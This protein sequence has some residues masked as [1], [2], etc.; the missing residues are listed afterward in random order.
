MFV[1]GRTM[2]SVARLTLRMIDFVRAAWIW[3]ITPC[4]AALDP[5]VP[6]VLLIAGKDMAARI[7]MIATT[8]S[9]S[10][11]VKPA[12]R[13]F[14]APSFEQEP[15]LERIAPASILLYFSSFEAMISSPRLTAL[16]P[17]DPC[18][19]KKRRA[20]AWGPRKGQPYLDLEAVGHGVAQA[21]D[22]RRGAS[23]A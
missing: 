7:T 21:R 15:C 20:Q 3:P 5:V 22:R 2:K 18:Y 13:R 4:R 9:N 16:D 17:D 6:D 11:T 14:I 19:E 1:S 12:S 10:I 8:I 23:R